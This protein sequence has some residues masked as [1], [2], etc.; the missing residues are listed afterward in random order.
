MSIM[1]GKKNSKFSF[2]DHT[3]DIMFRAEGK[4]LEEAYLNSALAL[5]EVMLGNLKVE[6]R[7]KR[8]ISVDGK[9]EE[10]LLMDFLEEFLYMLDAEDFIISEIKSLRIILSGRFKIEAEV[11]GDKASN[12]KFTNDVKAITYNEMFVKS[13][14]GKWTTQVVLDV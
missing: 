5:K 7:E 2:I 3:A 10:S 6:S 4:S 12:Y 1:K 8:T 11:Y 9:D 14:N 13:E